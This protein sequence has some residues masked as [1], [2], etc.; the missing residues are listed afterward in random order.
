V[1]AESIEEPFLAHIPV[2][3]KQYAVKRI[4]SSATAVCVVA[5]LGI[6]V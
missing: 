2:G 6:C 4:L 5:A 1:P 3:C